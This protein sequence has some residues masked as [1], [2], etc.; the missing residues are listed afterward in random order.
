MRDRLEKSVDLA[1][2]TNDD[3]TRDLYE[4]KA[5]AF[6]GKI[7]IT[8]KEIQELSVEPDVGTAEKRFPFSF[9]VSLNYRKAYALLATLPAVGG[10]Q[11]KISSDSHGAL[12]ACAY[13][14]F[15]FGGDGGSRT[16]VQGQSADTSTTIVRFIDLE[17]EAKKR[18]KALLDQSRSL[19][20]KVAP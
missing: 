9:S 2:T 16:P 14:E 12:W 8:E 11:H 7:E 3:E 4:K 13:L 18:T 20:P 5:K 19:N 17:L 10:S 6:G 15:N 1:V